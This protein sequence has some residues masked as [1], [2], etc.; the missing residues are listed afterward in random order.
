MS[1]KLVPQSGGDQD[2]AGAHRAAVG[3]RD[4]KAHSGVC[5]DT[6]DAA[7]HHQAAIALHLLAA[8]SEKVGR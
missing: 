4:A 3:Q 7:I 1:G 6:G 8:D 5:H 2:A